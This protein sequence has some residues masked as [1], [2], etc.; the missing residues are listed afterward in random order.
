[1]KNEK[2]MPKET[3]SVCCVSSLKAAR[4]EPPKG[5]REQKGK[6]ALASVGAIKQGK[7]RLTLCR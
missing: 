4:Q 7:N 5:R 2:W 1:V 6:L 3:H